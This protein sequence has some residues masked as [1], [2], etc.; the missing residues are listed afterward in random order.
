M[1]SLLSVEI[2]IRINEYHQSAGPDFKDVLHILINVYECVSPK[3][4]CGFKSQGEEPDIATG[5]WGCGA[6]NGDS[7]LKGKHLSLRRA[8]DNENRMKVELF[9]LLRLFSRDPA[10]GGSKSQAGVGV[11]HL[12]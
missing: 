4:Y 6:F 1:S 3:A 8:A 11:L 2:A 10:N 5:K 7:Q 12:Q 9:F